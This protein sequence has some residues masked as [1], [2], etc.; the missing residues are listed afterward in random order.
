M[1]PVL[2]L[3]DESSYLAIRWLDT[4]PQQRPVDL[5]FAEGNRAEA[6][7]IRSRYPTVSGLIPLPE[8][9]RPGPLD[10]SARST[11][12]G[13]RAILPVQ[14]HLFPLRYFKPNLLPNLNPYYAFFRKLW[15]LGFRHFEV[16]N[17]SGTTTFSIPH[18]LDEYVDRHKDRRCFVVGN[19]PSLND[20]D[21]TLLKNEI[22]LGAN[23]CYLGYEKWG[24]PFTYWGIADMLQIEECW[25]EYADNIPAET[26]KFY[27]FEYLP[28]LS[29]VNGC[30]VNA[31]TKHM[32][33]PK[34][35]D[36]CDRIHLGSTVTYLLL[37]I[38]A[39]MGCNP[40][41]LVGVDHRYPLKKGVGERPPLTERILGTSRRWL[42]RRLDGTLIHEFVRTYYRV[43]AESRPTRRQS[44]PKESVYWRDRDTTQPTH[45]DPRYTQGGERRF[46]VPVPR[47]ADRQFRL[48]ARWAE[49]K[50]VRIL[51]AT[52]NSALEAFP[53][54]P[55]ESLF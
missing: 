46:R 39:V 44:G 9:E 37:Q 21:M 2:F 47:W 40:I 20:V 6:E 45:F 43:R 51:N 5:L 54:V 42:E 50:G 55:Y 25:K 35:S 38:A 34:F 11:T 36:S 49:E 52:P 15:F 1:S 13:R 24:F 53:K 33:F 41:V 26:P 4:H 32:E 31:T 29:S 16:F 22:T 10:G 28:F 12:E 30:P 23:R 3:P 17:L 7:R 14:P 27:P 48:A 8:S 19:G 18:V